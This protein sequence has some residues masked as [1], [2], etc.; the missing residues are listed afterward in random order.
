MPLQT[1]SMH[2]MKYFIGTKVQLRTL[3]KDKKKENTKREIGDARKLQSP[4]EVVYNYL[5]WR[6]SPENK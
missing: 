1:K 5:I 2:V 4:S 6:F 3:H